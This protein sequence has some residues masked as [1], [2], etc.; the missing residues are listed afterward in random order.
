VTT[1]Y[2]RQFGRLIQFGTERSR[3]VART[4]NALTAAENLPGPSDFEATEKPVG[5][6][7]RWAQYLAVVPIQ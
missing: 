6:P 4:I 7:G 5:A 3:A 2:A 1:W